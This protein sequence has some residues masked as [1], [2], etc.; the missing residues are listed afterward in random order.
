[1]ELITTLEN[2]YHVKAGIRQCKLHRDI[3][4]TTRSSDI[5]KKSRL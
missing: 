2:I 1:M 5:Y 4:T 3:G